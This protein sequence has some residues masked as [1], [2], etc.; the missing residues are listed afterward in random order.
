MEKSR[1]RFDGYVI[2]S[3]FE[4][5]TKYQ[6]HEA[7]H[8]WAVTFTLTSGKVKQFYLKARNYEEALEK[9]K[10]YEYLAEITLKNGEWRLLP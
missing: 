2:P 10:S 1:F 4:D 7:V 3:H 8:Y 5:F 9:A 6:K